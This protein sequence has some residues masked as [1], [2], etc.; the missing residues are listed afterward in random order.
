MFWVWTW[1]WTWTCGRAGCDGG[2]GG[3][4]DGGAGC[5]CDDACGA[6][7]GCRH[8]MG[9]LGAGR[10]KRVAGIAAAVAVVAA[11]GAENFL[12]CPLPP[13]PSLLSCFLCVFSSFFF[14]FPFSFFF[15]LSFPFLTVKKGERDF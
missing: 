10:P 7:A 2:C 13:K 3:D 5:G 15:F 9:L 11:A 1:T 14:F 12:D 8:Y 6:A 4:G